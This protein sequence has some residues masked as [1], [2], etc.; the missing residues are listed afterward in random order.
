MLEILTRI[1]EGN[2]QAGDIE[3]LEELCHAIKDGALCGLGQTAPNPV[4]T[5]IKYFKDEYIDHIENKKCT[6]GECRELVKYEISADKCR[7]C[8]LCARSCPVNAITG[9]VKEPHTIDTD[10][11]IKCG[12]CYESC[13]FGAIV[14]E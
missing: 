3:L 2:G 5:T 14:K 4:L 6:A 12:K 1:T 11:C 13:R 8:T 7:G 9:S 10:K